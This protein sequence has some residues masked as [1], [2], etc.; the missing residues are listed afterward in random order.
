MTTKPKLRTGS[1]LL[2][3]LA[4]VALFV[5]LAAAIVRA[6]FGDPQGFAADAPITASIGYAMFNLDMGAVPGEG[7]IVAFILI[8]VVLDAALDGALLLAKREEEGS[9]VA[10]LADGGRQVRDRLRD[11][12]ETDA[13]EG[14]DR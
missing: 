9:A 8:A 1:H 12:T 7:M 6:S 13:D 3:G 2:P 10:L 11:D 5:V 14:G 4:A